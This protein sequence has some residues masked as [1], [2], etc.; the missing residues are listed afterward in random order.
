MFNSPAYAAAQRVLW[1]DR[2][3][4]TTKQDT[5]NS[6][7]RTVQEDVVLFADE[8]CRLSFNSVTETDE[9]SN[10][11]R[12]VQSAVLLISQKRTIPA[13]SIITVTHEGVTSTFERSGVAAVYSYH[14]EIP[15][16]LKKEWA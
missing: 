9:T 14:Q 6:K 4:V 5:V 13:G 10:A 3:T 12:R 11:A 7:K 1:C 16:V 8:P 15:L 2:C